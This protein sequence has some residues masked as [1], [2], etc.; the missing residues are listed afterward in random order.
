MVTEH[1]EVLLNPVTAP[2]PPFLST[3]STW[4]GACGS[5][6]TSRKPVPFSAPQHTGQFG[7]EKKQEGEGIT[8]ETVLRGSGTA[9][10]KR[11]RRKKELC[12]LAI[13]KWKVLN[14]T[15]P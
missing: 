5:G 10:K 3:A 11:I 12:G 15:G 8:G 7:G 2:Q 1:W 13:I 9:Y 6:G 4:R 14:T